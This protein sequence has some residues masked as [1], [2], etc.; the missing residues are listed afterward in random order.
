MT[1]YEAWWFLTEH[2]IYIPKKGDPL[3]GES[4]FPHN[5]TLDI[6]VAKVDLDHNLLEDYNEEGKT[7]IWLE[8]G[9]WYLSEET[10]EHTSSI[11]GM[12]SHDYRLDVTGDTFEEAIIHLAEKVKEY[13]TDEGEEKEP[14]SYN[15]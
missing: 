12:P 4:I 8:S 1:F 14:I 15:I 6:F 7:E 9:P 5:G 11:P 10:E 2:P 3:W 13:Y